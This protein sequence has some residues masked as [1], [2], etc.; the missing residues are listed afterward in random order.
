MDIVCKAAKNV[1]LD[2]AARK[3]R[4][5]NLAVGHQDRNSMDSPDA[6]LNLHADPPSLKAV[7][8]ANALRGKLGVHLLGHVRD[9]FGGLLTLLERQ[10]HVFRVVRI[11]KNDHVILL[12][13][14]TPPSSRGVLPMPTDMTPPPIAIDQEFS[15]RSGKE[16]P[17]AGLGFHPQPPPG[18]QISKGQLQENPYGF[19][20][21]G[22]PM[23]RPSPLNAPPSAQAFET[24]PSATGPLTQAPPGL[25]IPPA[26]ENHP[27]LSAGLYGASNSLGSS[28]LSD[29]VG[30]ESVFTALDSELDGAPYQKA[31]NDAKLIVADTPQ[32]GNDD[33]SGFFSD[34]IDGLYGQDNNPPELVRP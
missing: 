25:D 1:L 20:N 27:S 16:P 33:A 9:L 8:L 30:A 34:L 7:E 31:W 5:G 32:P 12:E 22:P 4:G 6:S 19:D 17:A 26:G 3:N 14:P 24:A 2:A 21:R 10:P 23:S 15:S 11:P 28:G 29:E 18:V 13:G